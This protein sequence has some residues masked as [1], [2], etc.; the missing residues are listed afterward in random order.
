MADRPKRPPTG[1]TDKELFRVTRPRIA[2]PPPLPPRPAHRSKPGLDEK[3]AE[4]LRAY[5]NGDEIPASEPP[6]PPSDPDFESSLD[7]NEPPP[8]EPRR[9]I[10]VELPPDMTIRPRQSWTQKLGHAQKIIIGVVGIGGALTGTSTAVYRG[11]AAAFRWYASRTST[12]DL[13]AKFSACSELVK[14][15][16]DRADLDALRAVVGDA[17]ASN[18]DNWDK[19]DA[20]NQHVYKELNRLRLQTPPPPLGPKAKASG[21]Q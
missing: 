6:P 5:V 18:G 16:T 3:Q 2:P 11:G 7:S 14:S 12:E 1:S 15:K 8:R 17:G 9:R 19:Q 13:E 21:R 10:M 4:M 20:I